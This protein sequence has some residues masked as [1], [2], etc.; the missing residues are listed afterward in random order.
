MA[1]VRTRGDR[2]IEIPINPV[3]GLEHFLR[4]VAGQPRQ[5]RLKCDGRSVLL[6]SPGV[7]H[8]S[9]S[10]RFDTVLKEVFDVLDIDALAM[11]STLYRLPEPDRNKA[12]EPDQ[13]YYIANWEKVLGHKEIDLSVS[14]PPD[15]VIE[16]V[17]ANPA[18]R[19]LGL[20]LKLR[21]PEVWVY[22]VRK[23]Q[24]VF[25]GLTEEAGQPARYRDLEQS[26]VLP[27]LTPAD[28]APWGEVAPESSK[29]F[30]RRA[31]QWVET[32]ILP[33]RRG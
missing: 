15:L 29:E 14:P 19:S 28:L 11:A 18:M 2:I 8:E 21:V 20:C 17:D 32:E 6:V 10:D 16:V 4:A 13:S 23:R 9:A 27:F 1:T 12:F 31:R 33:R 30:K 7:P 25:K 24:L 22:K 5:G 3:D 26:R